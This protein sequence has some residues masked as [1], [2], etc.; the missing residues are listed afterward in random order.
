MQNISINEVKQRLAA[1]EQ[2]HIIDV[3]EPYEYAEF[4]IDA[5]LIPLGKI[6]SMQVE[7]IEDW[8]NEEVIV[9]CRSGARSMQACMILESIGFAN[10]KNLEGGMLQWQQ[11]GGPM[12]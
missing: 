10:T 11:Q 12:R 5:K 4:N 8:K 9:H 2:L 7:D 1:G 6:Q 3:R